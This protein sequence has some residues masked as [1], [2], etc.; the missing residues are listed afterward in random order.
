MGGLRGL[1]FILSFPIKKKQYYIP[2]KILFNIITLTAFDL[3]EHIY[4][5]LYL[6]TFSTDT[7]D[8]M[9]IF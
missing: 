9:N 8:Q 4:V 6:S 5:P 7:Q 1:L 3:K 2:N